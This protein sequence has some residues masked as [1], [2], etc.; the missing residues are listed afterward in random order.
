[1]GKVLLVYPYFQSS[2][3][4]EFRF[5]PLGLGYIA[6]KLCNHGIDVE[7]LDCTFLSGLDEAVYQVLEKDPSIIG[8]YSI[9]TLNENA[10]SLGKRLHE[11]CEILVA[12]GPLPSADPEPFLDVF[13]IV[14]IGEGE[15]T[16]LEI[17]KQEKGVNNI[18]GIAYKEINGQLSR[19]SSDEGYKIVKNEPREL[20]MDI[21]SIPFPAR[22][23]FENQKYIN[24]YQRKGNKASTSIMSSRGCLYKCE[25]CS[26]SIFGNSFRERS[27]ENIIEEIKQVLK[28][29][30][31]KV[32]FQD[33]SFTITKERV[34]NFC[35]KVLQSGLYFEWD[36]LSRVD[37]IDYD[38]AFLMKKAGCQRVFFGL[39]SG[40]DEILNLMNKQADK[41]QAIKAINS[42]KAAGIRAGAFFIIGYP[43]ETDD[44][45]LETINFASS[46]NLDYLSFNTYMGAINSYLKAKYLSVN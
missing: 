38:T 3:N 27:P 44:S 4:S 42:T 12:G 6:S 8:I 1:M 25:F 19:S 39:E 16:M 17:A 36:C 24:Y 41:T 7:I 14:V 28:L 5:P 29:G 20:I 2:R 40:N 22:D 30:Y 11:N 43:G 46:L 15:E 9:F 34:V 35:Q 31:E 23:L 26:R 32:V 10:L 45:L 21:N 13:D 37:S 33:D 18:N